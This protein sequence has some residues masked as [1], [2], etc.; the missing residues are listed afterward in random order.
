MFF[1]KQND[2]LK[3]EIQ[4]LETE[5]NTLGSRITDLEAELAL[6]QKELDSLEAEK[7]TKNTTEAVWL[8]SQNALSEIR[9]SIATSADMLLTEKNKLTDTETLFSRTHEI[10]DEIVSKLNEIATHAHDSVTVSNELNSHSSEIKNF[11]N[12]INSISEQTNLLALNAAIEAARA[13]E[14]G[15]GFA[16]VADEVR[17]LAQKAADASSEIENLVDKIVSSSN[18]LER[19]VEKVAAQ[20]EDE[21]AAVSEIESLM[22]K[23]VNI[24]RD[25]RKVV[26]NSANHTFLDATKLDHVVWKNDVYQCC[27]GV[28]GSA[29]EIATSHKECNLGQWYYHGEGHAR[30]AQSSAYKQL[31]EPHRKVHECGNLAME[32]AQNGDQAG[33]LRA[34]SEM[35]DASNRVIRIL[36]DLKHTI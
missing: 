5:R 32:K 33:A 35:E 26:E 17:S 23:V 8:R 4:A 36:E 6:K 2:A 25:M 30:Y 14:A 7:D 12:V 19:N 29:M 20:S 9:G 28:G 13:G 22:D 24:S 16:V 11:V 3:S 34:L 15:R 1:N 31:E 18:I 10:T 21:R 27:M